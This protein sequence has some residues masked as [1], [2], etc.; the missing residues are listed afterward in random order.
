MRYKELYESIWKLKNKKEVLTLLELDTVV[1]IENVHLLTT[2]L[3]PLFE[4]KDPSIVSDQ[5]IDVK[6]SIDYLQTF[7]EKKLVMI[8]FMG[9]N[10][11]QAYDMFLSKH[12]NYVYEEGLFK[13]Q[14]TDEML[15][16]YV[17]KFDA[18][19]SVLTS[20]SS[21]HVHVNAVDLENFIYYYDGENTFTN[22]EYPELFDVLELMAIQGIHKNGLL[23]SNILLSIKKENESSFQTLMKIHDST[24]VQ[25]LI[26]STKVERRRFRK[27][28]LSSGMQKD[29]IETCLLATQNL[30]VDIYKD[31]KFGFVRDFLI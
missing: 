14:E 5:W 26:N 17:I 6:P 3:L 25:S 21:I 1:E 22:S 16:F 9:N 19:G 23:L 29:V 10:K 28:A 12:D 11:Q 30:D 15:T 24:F 31:Y 8:R 27:H 20:L 13:K 2:M 18:L 7:L 4:E